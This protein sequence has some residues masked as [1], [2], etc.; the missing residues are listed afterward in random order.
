MFRYVK[1]ELVVWAKRITNCRIR[2]LRGDPREDFLPVGSGEMRPHL[3]IAQN[4]VVS[5][6]LH[7]DK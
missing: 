7:M 5:S 1:K 4:T 2:M 6:E 3:P